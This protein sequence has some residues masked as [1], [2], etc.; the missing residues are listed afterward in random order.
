[1]LMEGIAFAGARLGRTADVV[2]C[3]RNGILVMLSLDVL[4]PSCGEGERCAGAGETP[5]KWEVVEIAEVCGAAGDGGRGGGRAG[6]EGRWDCG[7]T[8]VGEMEVDEGWFCWIGSR[9]CGSR[10]AAGR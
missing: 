3:V 6:E 1:M 5:G 2:V 10:G 8:K 4:S 7:F 9:Y